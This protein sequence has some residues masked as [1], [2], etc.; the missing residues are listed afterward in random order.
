MARPLRIEYPGT[1]YYITNR[2]NDKKAVLK[3][4]AASCRE[5]SILKEGGSI[6][7]IAR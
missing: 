6:F 7:L 3:L 2:G 1:G 4:P 5:S